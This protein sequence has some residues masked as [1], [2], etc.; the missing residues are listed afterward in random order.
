MNY[1]MFNGDGSLGSDKSSE[2]K[3]RS[4]RT[5]LRLARERY[6]IKGT[7]RKICLTNDGVHIWRVV[8]TTYVFSLTRIA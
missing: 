4:I 8:G 3:A 1:Y 7:I 2:I 5:A 6:H